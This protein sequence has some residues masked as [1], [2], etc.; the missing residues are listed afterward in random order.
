[1]LRQKNRAF[2]IHWDGSSG[3]CWVLSYVGRSLFN[4]VVIF[5]D[6]SPVINFFKK[7][8]GTARQWEDNGEIG[9]GEG[10]KQKTEG[11]KRQWGKK[12]NNL[13]LSNEWCMYVCMYVYILWTRHYISLHCVMKTI[14]WIVT[15]QGRCNKVS[16]RVKTKLLYEDHGCGWLLAHKIQTNYRA[17]CV[18][19]FEWGLHGW[20]VSMNHRYGQI[21]LLENA[22]I[23]NLQTP[24]RCCQIVYPDSSRSVA[25]MDYWGVRD[26][27]E[28]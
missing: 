2:T 12:N 19:Y 9:G 13:K 27:A 4:M 22:N 28:L 21:K 1:M 10:E 26:K 15:A 11:C 18:Q 24:H 23:N 14:Q 8:G 6:M 17:I 16:L 25:F 20:G 3:P 5:L 7:E